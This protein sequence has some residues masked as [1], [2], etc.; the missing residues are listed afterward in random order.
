MLCANRLPAFSVLVRT[1]RAF[2]RMTEPATRRPVKKIVIAILSVIAIAV[3]TVIVIGVHLSDPY[4]R[5]KAIEMLGEK[6]HA[7][8]ELKDFHVTCFPGRALKA[9]D[10]CCGIRGG[11]TC[12]LSFPSASFPPKLESSD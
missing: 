1:G 8:V 10:W 3:V 6:F 12:L 9:R 2:S 7:S 5:K 4:L 11:P